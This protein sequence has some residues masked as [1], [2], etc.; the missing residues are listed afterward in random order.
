MKH[1]ILLIGVFTILTVFACSRLALAQEKAFTPQ[2]LAQND[3]KDGHAAF[4]AYKGKVYDV[5]T[6]S[7]WK[8]GEHFGLH[9]GVD[10]TDKMAG[11]PHGEEVLSKFPV[12]GTFGSVTSSP[13]P[14]VDSIP[15]KAPAAS[16]TKHWYDA[17]IRI[18][19]ISIIGW[20]GILL[21]I[22]FVLNFAT[23]FAL[24]W[25]KLPLPWKG[26]RPGPDA[27]DGAPVHLNFASI[28]KYFA[29]ATVIVG[30]V[31]GVLGLLQLLGFYL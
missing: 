15:E 27:L 20:T 31:H 21:G 26:K 2:E 22:V 30:I 3:G 5:S 8:L 13:A 16:S 24:P 7:F 25:G 1:K 17:P 4:F 29:W 19:G 9:A 23:C 11:A 10:L 6:S 12:V 18:A 28:H 14:A